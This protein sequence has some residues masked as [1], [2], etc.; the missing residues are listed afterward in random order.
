MD[1]NENNLEQIVEFIN[2]E[3]S[4]GRTM[5]EIEKNDF[6]VNERV[7]TKRLKRKGYTKV[8]NQ[9]TLKEWVEH[10]AINNDS[11]ATKEVNTTLTK[12]VKQ[13]YN[14]SISK[15]KDKLEE[16]INLLEPIKEVIQ[17]YNKSKTIVEV[18]PIELK[19][20]HI[21]EVKQKLFKI[22][23]DVLKEWEKFVAEH[24]QFKVQNLISLALEEF[25]NKYE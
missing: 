7:I 8:N 11:L 5:V 3:L 21:T 14:N 19:V 4:K 9:F 22:D 10:Q 12:S 25:M 23:S 20:K 17:E 13:K 6:N 1:Y 16:L 15:D 24:K 18:E 2:G